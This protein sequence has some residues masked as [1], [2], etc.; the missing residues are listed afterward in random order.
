VLSV[1]GM[2]QQAVLVIAKGGVRGRSGSD[3]CSSRKAAVEV[4]TIE[5]MVLMIRRGGLLDASLVADLWL[6]ARRFALGA[7]PAPVHSDDEVR[8]WFAS[9]VVSELELWIAESKNGELLGMLVLD[10]EWIDQLYVDP[11]HTGHGIGSRLLEVAKRERP[12][13]LRLWTF[14]SN[15]D[16]RTR[17]VPR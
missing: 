16:S 7:V 9:H 15:S 6:C 12:S 10:G 11:T 2:R 8:S 3:A 13:G 1:E 14:V 5:G 4:G 17:V